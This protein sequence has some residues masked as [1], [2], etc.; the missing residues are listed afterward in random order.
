M[1]INL[2]V[3]QATALFEAALEVPG[4]SPI[5]ASALHGAALILR[6]ALDNPAQDCDACGKC[7]RINDDGTTDCD[8]VVYCLTCGDE[9]DDEGTYCAPC[10]RG[11]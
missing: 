11:E 6:A 3:A 8:E 1:R 4:D 10:A 5:D 2:D 9:I 7:H